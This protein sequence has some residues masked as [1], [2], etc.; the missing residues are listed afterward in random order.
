MLIEFT[1]HFRCMLLG[2]WISLI[3]IQNGIGQILLFHFVVVRHVSGNLLNQRQQYGLLQRARIEHRF[4]VGLFQCKLDQTQ[5]VGNECLMEGRIY[6]SLS[7]QM[8]YLLLHVENAR[9]CR[10]LCLR[11]THNRQD[12]IANGGRLTFK[13][14]VNLNEKSYICCSSN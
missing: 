13:A 11:S 4:V 6:L 10:R 9:R 8:L 1:H 12:G 2:R 5:V 7:Q 14:F 3:Q